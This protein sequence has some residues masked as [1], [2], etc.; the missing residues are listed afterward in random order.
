[1][2]W[3]AWL[4]VI[5]GVIVGVS[6][7]IAY[8]LI[9]DHEKVRASKSRIKE[10]QT[11]IKATQPTDPSFKSLQ[12][13]L[14]SENAKIMKQTMK[15][16][17]VTFIPFLIIF[18]LVE[19]YLSAVPITIGVPISAQIIGN[20][21]GNIT[22]T[23]LMIG[24]GLTRP[25]SVVNG[26]TFNATVLKDNCTL[27][28]ISN[29]VKSNVSL[30]GLV[31]S[32]QK[33]VFS[34]DGVKLAFTPNDLIVASFYLPPFGMIYINWFWAYLIFSLISGLGLNRV[35]IHYKLVA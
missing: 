20:F 35:F 3:E 32:V 12:T 17:Y 14:L 29:H 8:L 18:V 23:C 34:V 27:F 1:M 26:M 28:L 22:S 21:T 2:I 30:S 7:Q 33:K 16:T 4:V 31:G 10:L 15:P 13:E 6:G 25:V 24:G 9:V 5:L 11:K 19:M